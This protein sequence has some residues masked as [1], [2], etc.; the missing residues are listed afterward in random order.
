[1]I[2]PSSVVLIS[3]LRNFPIS[4]KAHWKHLRSPALYATKLLQLERP[5]RSTLKGCTKRSISDFLFFFF[6]IVGADFFK[7]IDLI[8]KSKIIQRNRHEFACRDCG[9]VARV[10]NNLAKHVEDRHVEYGGITCTFCGK[11][12]PSRNAL[13]T[14]HSRYHRPN[15]NNWF[16]VF[17]HEKYNFKIFRLRCVCEHRSWNQGMLPKDGWRRLPLQS[18]SSHLCPAG[19]HG[20]PRRGEALPRPRHNLLHLSEA[21]GHPP[22]L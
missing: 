8:I 16:N 1:M 17:F 22:V 15:K 3:H 14:H 10:Y 9:R 19:Q 4:V 2:L 18:L 12:C 7:E 13:A 21:P 11:H 5:L 6:S 20:Q